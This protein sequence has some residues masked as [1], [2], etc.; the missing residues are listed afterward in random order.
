MKHDSRDAAAGI[1]P[2]ASGKLA[3]VAPTLREHGKVHLLT[4]GTKTLNKD[5]HGQP[6]GQFQDPH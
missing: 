2:P 3:Y 5:A 6:G 4:Q 1:P